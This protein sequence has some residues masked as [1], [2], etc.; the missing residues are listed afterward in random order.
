MSRAPSSACSARLRPG[1]NPAR[2]RRPHRPL[3]AAW[4]THRPQIPSAVSPL[5]RDVREHTAEEAG[6]VTARGFV[7]EPDWLG[8]KRRRGFDKDR[9][10]ARTGRGREHHKRTTRRPYSYE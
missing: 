1:E 9:N 6:E 5:T 8:T 3:P 10:R 4:R 7:L 2:C